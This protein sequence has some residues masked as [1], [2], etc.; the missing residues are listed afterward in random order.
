MVSVDSGFWDRRNDGRRFFSLG[1]GLETVRVLVT[2]DGEL[3]GTDGGRVNGKE[4]CKDEDVEVLGPP[5]AA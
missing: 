2:L 4:L 3:V 5:E 1:R